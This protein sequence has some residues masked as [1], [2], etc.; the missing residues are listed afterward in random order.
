MQEE[1]K[2]ALDKYL[3]DIANEEPLTGAE[4]KDLSERIRH[5][6]SKAA[7][8]LITANLRFVVSMARQYQD[9]GVS[10]QDLVSEGNIG[11]IRA[12]ERYDASLGARFVSYAAPFVRKCM[13]QA[14]ERQA[15]IYHVSGSEKTKSAKRHGRV[16]SADASLGGRENVNLLNLIENPDAPETDAMADRIVLTEELGRQLSVLTERER[17]VVLLF[18]GIGREKLTFAEIGERMGLKRERVRQIR[19]RAVRKITRSA[20]KDVMPA[21]FGV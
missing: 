8:R 12:V 14:V 13:E 16:L 6:D 19:D 15:G 7:E 20:G 4:E 2:N 11:L 17:Q 21:L 1:E 18:F 10:I 3:K 5:G 9:K